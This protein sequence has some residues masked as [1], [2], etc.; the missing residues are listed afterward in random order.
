MNVMKMTRIC[1][2]IVLLLLAVFP[3]FAQEGVASGPPAI[4]PEQLPALVFL[5]QAGPKDP[6]AL[7]LA[8]LEDGKWIKSTLVTRPFVDALLVNN[9]ELIVTMGDSAES[10]TVNYALPLEGKIVPIS[11]VPMA[12]LTS[13]ETVL[14]REL[15]AAGGAVTHLL[16]NDVE[17]NRF[18][19]LSF[20]PKVPVPQHLYF[21]VPRFAEA[22]ASDAPVRIAPDGRHL[23]SIVPDPDA[24]EDAPA[25]ILFVVHVQ[26][27]SVT[28]VARG[29]PAY[30]N[31]AG[32]GFDWQDGSVLVY[33][34]V[35]DGNALQ[36]TSHTLHSDV[37]ERLYTLNLPE[38]ETP[39]GLFH[40]WGTLDWYLETG[41]KGNRQYRIFP[42]AETLADN[43]EPG[44]ASLRTSE[45]GFEVHFKGEV[46][47]SGPQ[48]VKALRYATTPDEAYLAFSLQAQGLDDAP[49]RMIMHIKHGSEEP[50][51]AQ[52]PRFL[53]KPVGW[54][55]QAPD[56]S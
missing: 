36:F 56:A 4:T 51:Q 27:N 40:A 44:R 26:E 49:Q 45:T 24:P 1:T 29:I 47:F 30:Q 41:L 37:K 13:P 50:V 38:I 18:A 33:A 32:V 21:D 43:P 52:V 42:E 25:Y 53:L 11:P 55:T 48:P 46:C 20:T 19:V 39:F 9:S 31:G 15:V 14:G 10:T 23:A 34:T 8:R 2:P 22:M 54:I 6:I 12:A 28:E 35:E 7:K 16:R 17:H 3:A 5:E